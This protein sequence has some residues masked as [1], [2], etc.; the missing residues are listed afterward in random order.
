MNASYIIDNNLQKYSELKKNL[1]DNN[2][3]VKI[4]S[5][6]ELFTPAYWKYICEKTDAVKNPSRYHLGVSLQEEVVACL[7]GGHGIKGEHGL[8]AF[9]ALK[10][11]GIITA[12]SEINS[13]D[14]EEILRQPITINGRSIKYRF[15]K[16]KAIY[17]SGALQK[18]NN[19]S[20]PLESGQALRNWLTE[21][22]GVGVKT[23]S[24]VARNWLDADDV[25]II[26]IHIQRASVLMGLFY[27]Q[28]KVTKDYLSMEHRFVQLAKSI[29]VP[30][31]VLDNVIWNE[32]RQTPSVV[33]RCLISMGVHAED[34]C[35]LPT[36]N[37]RNTNTTY[38]LF[39]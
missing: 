8:S 9:N 7:L 11:T 25:A 23:A 13:N 18:L 22:K 16:Q 3:A 21:I 4:G 31:S 15:P 10:N 36:P 27:P 37:K 6:D 34:P 12:A 19:E 28:E 24:W 35:G 5:P 2:I 38:S 26:D 17:I 30:T 14:I 32:I 1:S 20:P 39:S 33:R 29:G